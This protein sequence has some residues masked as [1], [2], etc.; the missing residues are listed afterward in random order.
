[1]TNLK[2]S[3]MDR[4]LAIYLV[5][6]RYLQSDIPLLT[7]TYTPAPELGAPEGQ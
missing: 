4:T 6:Q 1:M 2:S 5:T 3:D 7:G